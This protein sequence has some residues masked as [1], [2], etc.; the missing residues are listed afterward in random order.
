MH[1]KLTYSLGVMLLLQ[2]TACSRKAP[3][4]PTSVSSETPEI[5]GVS[6]WDRISTRSQALRS[7]PRTTL[8]SLGESFVYLD[9]F[10]IDSSEKNTKFLRA[11]LSDSTEVWVYD[12]ACVLDA[13]PAVVIHEVPLYMRPDLLTITAERLGTMEIIAVVEEWD[14]WIKVVGEKKEKKGWIKK[15]SISYT[16][17]DLAF[18]LLCKRTLEE[19]DLEEK[20]DR[21]EELLA[22]NPYP[23]TIFIEAFKERV[24]QEKQLLWEYQYERDRENRD[25]EDQDRR[26]RR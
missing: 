20:V 18:A 24:D 19:E 1:R 23:N 2:M 14:D 11:R 21:L 15:E 4:E 5:I 12:F 13:K 7:S 9:T 3:E 17:I 6:V 22:N 8:L 25:R 10:A 16:S 26:R